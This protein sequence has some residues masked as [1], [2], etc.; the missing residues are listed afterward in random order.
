MSEKKNKNENQNS[1][2]EKVL[3]P[4]E[5]AAALEAKGKLL[6]EKLEKADGLIQ[7]L[8]SQDGKIKS[9]VE[10]ALAQAALESGIA[11]KPKPRTNSNVGVNKGQDL[12][13]VGKD[14]I[15]AIHKGIKSFTYAN[16]AQI[17]KNQLKNWEK[18]GYKQ[19]EA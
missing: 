18:N 2:P 15:D 4:E 3:S 10:A 6:D 16:T 11:P 1:G 12:I 7:K 14:R 13:T 5:T 19:I 9:A 8:E 17:Q